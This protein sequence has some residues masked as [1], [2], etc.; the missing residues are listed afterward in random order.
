MIP[1]RLV[2]VLQKCQRQLGS[3]NIHSTPRCNA[4]YS[5]T[6]RKIRNGQSNQRAAAAPRQNLSVDEALP[7]ITML[8]VAKKSG[9]ID[10]EPEKALEFLREY[11]KASASS[12]GDW[13]QKLCAEHG[14]TP[15][16]LSILSG[17]LRRC[18]AH[19]QK[20]LAKRLMLSASKLGEKSA[21]FELVLSAIKADGLRGNEVQAP[22]QRLNQLAKTDNEPLA[23]TLLGKVL[24]AQGREREA[25]EWLRKATQPPTG[26]IDFD[27]A[28][29]AL[30]DEGRALLKL[31]KLVAANAVFKQ[32]ALELDEPEAYLHLSNFQEPGSQ[33]QTEYLMKAASSGVVEAWYKL[34]EHEFQKITKSELKPEKIG[35]FG[36]AREW[37]QL[38]ADGGSGSAMLY[39]AQ[40]L[41]VVGMGE[42]G[43]LWV[44]RALDVPDVADLARGMK[45]QWESREFNLYDI[46]QAQG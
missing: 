36:M 34:G 28:G 4:A 42:D 26:N 39:M 16:A 46:S 40:M 24:M 15:F 12:T 11:T 3:R 8:S 22:L 18:R 35:D 10:I 6:V 30:V 2:P 29:A 21:T 32:A 19:P 9:V 25:L 7:P 13:E 33:T 43:L 27:G 37:F 14:V 38:A 31:E 45:E 44:E 5:P 41:R 20:I 1:R 23:M 17:I